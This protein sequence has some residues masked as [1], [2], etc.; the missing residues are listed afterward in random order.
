MPLPPW[1][2]QVRSGSSC[3]SIVILVFGGLQTHLLNWK[4]FSFH[5]LQ[6]EALK[7]HPW[8]LTWN[9][10][11]TPWKRRS[12]LATIIFYVKLLLGFATL[13][14]GWKKF[15]LSFS[16]MVGFFMLMNPM[17]FQSVKKKQHQS[18]TNKSKLEAVTFHKVMF[19]WISRRIHGTGI[20]TLHLAKIYR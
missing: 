20:F 15:Q 3:F 13:Q 9:R 2:C 4:G 12:L 18:L 19:P 17:G 6:K 11:M 16:Q 5:G 7:K 14:C 8:S 10:K 1:S